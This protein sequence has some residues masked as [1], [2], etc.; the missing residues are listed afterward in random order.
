[1]PYD[2][3]LLAV[4]LGAAVGVVTTAPSQPEVLRVEGSSR[5]V[6]NVGKAGA[7]SFAGHAHEVEAPVT[8]RVSVNR[9]DLTRSEVWL[10]FDSASLRVTGQGEPAQDVPEVQRVMLSERVLD[11]KRYPTIVFH[12]RRITTAGSSGAFVNVSV[13]G[14]LTLRGVTKPVIVPV[15][16]ALG[17]GSVTA[18]GTVTL[19]Q[20]DFGIQPVTAAGGAVR[21]KDA[22]E[23]TFSL[24]AAR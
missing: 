7:F 8:G 1:M 5:V 21:V 11:V 10:E 6:I 24:Q 19:K 18:G 15:R 17:D 2:E 22:L 20:S 16:I 12:S 13:A 9:S 3:I 4:W 23:I 14:D